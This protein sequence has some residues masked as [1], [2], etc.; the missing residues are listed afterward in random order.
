M[1]RIRALAKAPGV[2]DANVNLLMNSATVAFDPTAT[3]PEKLIETIRA[4]GYDASLP[5]PADNAKDEQE[6]PA[7][8]RAPEN[9]FFPLRHTR[10]PVT[11]IAVPG[12]LGR[13]LP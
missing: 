13:R 3:T 12:E 5:A 6:A 9:D 4:T 1:T 8:Y 2:A 7:R 10:S 11:S